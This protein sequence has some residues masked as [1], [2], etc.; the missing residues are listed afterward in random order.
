[1][2]KNRLC[3]IIFSF[4]QFFSFALPQDCV[5][6]FTLENGMSIFLLEDSSEA[7]VHLEVNVKAGFSSQNK[8]NSGFFYLYADLIQNSNF[9]D[10]DSVTCNADSSRF[11]LTATNNEIEEILQKLSSLILNFSFSDELLEQEISK[12]KKESE[13]NSKTLGGFLNS[14]IES[15]IYSNSPWKHDSGI[16]PAFF[17]KNTL[18]TARTKLQEISERFYTP[19]N[20]AIFITGNINSEKI[21]KYLRNSFGKYYSTYKTPNFHSDIPFNSQKK[22]VIHSSDFSPEIT[23]LVIEYT[24]FSN[25]ESEIF[26]LALND[27]YSTFKTELLKNKNLNI[28]GSDYIDVNATHTKDSSRII[29]Q[30]LLQK[31]EETK[32]SSLEQSQNFLEIVNKIPEIFINEE[33]VFAKQKFNQ[34]FYEMTS[35][36]VKMMDT[37]SS[38]WNFEP[39]CDIS[40]N[41]LEEYPNSYTTGNLI[42]QT[43]KYEN[44][45]IQPILK[46]L[47]N[48]EP[49]IFVIISDDD[50]KKQKKEYQKAGF[51]EINFKNASWYTMQMEKE[52][53]EQFKPSEE[54]IFN[55]SSN[56]FD[57]NNFY[58]KNKSDFQFSN[59]SN[60][61]NVVV[62]EN[63]NSSDFTFIL[64]I[65]GGKLNSASD[66]GFEE[67]MIN[68]ISMMIQRKINSKFAEGFILQ[69]PTFSTKTELKTSYISITCN[70]N[71]F[72]E[73]CNSIN[74][75]L[76]FSD[77][78]PAI[79][80][81]AVSSRQYKTRL[82]NGS[83][84]NQMIFSAIK[85]I[86]KE[87]DLV[88]IF[89][90][91]KEILQDT[92][93]LKILNN[94]PNF[95]D[96]SRFSFILSGNIPTRWNETLEK[97]FGL[98]SKNNVI[99]N[100]PQIKEDFP[101]NKTE[102]VKINHTFLTDIP[103]EKAGP[104]P[105]VLIPTTE[106]LDPVIY[107]LK[108]P[109]QNSKEFCIFN[110]MLNFLG[111]ELQNEID[112]S[113]KNK[114]AKV[115]IQFPNSEMNIGFL[116]IQNVSH[117]NEIDILYKNLIKNLTKTIDDK[118]SS[119]IKSLWIKNQLTNTVSSSQT[120]Q[121]IFRGLE[122][123]PNQNKYDFYLDEYK[124]I[125]EANVQDYFE[126]LKYFPEN[127]NLKIYSK[128][129][130]K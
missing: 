115:L 40:E 100:Q 44:V 84:V 73:I 23:Q 93:Y 4:F 70:K 76:I 60:G 19:Q 91:S 118:I 47:K 51:Q 11:S 83:S 99:L 50:F 102:F 28:P 124:I 41:F 88:Q 68:I 82:E 119:K 66:N 25:E 101:Q 30:S 74:S 29:I 108:S 64:A 113:K 10:F 24:N 67:V 56:N 13:E 130:K 126:I 72:E 59:L 127:P 15:R 86:Y 61:I 58:E 21:L 75:V 39:F 129:S 81:R 98:L 37:L 94:Y 6:Q 53:Q 71:D 45:E 5:K 85:I 3:F 80:D 8:N 109:S 36:S 52:I 27:N 14:A 26:S 38:F 106:F 114:N 69:M 49:F 1:M 32:I 125:T 110:A 34:I 105:E 7:L 35:N 121:L 33:L 116:I 117:T 92:D 31:S 17:K 55:P 42:F 46:T 97:N 95:L 77:P 87:S 78:I 63:K 123:F 104:Q 12:L 22:Y 9:L 79:A 20:S 128:E 122:L 103:A 120:A 16:Y 54:E 2:R 107:V 111:D 89:D 90:T 43:K 62:K 18:K 48:E 112:K 96:S 65:D 57:D